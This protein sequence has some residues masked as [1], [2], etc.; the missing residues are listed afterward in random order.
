M[1]PLATTLFS[2]TAL[3]VAALLAV[4]PAARAQTGSDAGLA[5]LR[6]E[7]LRA[8]VGFLASDALQGRAAGT[9][10]NDIAAEY[11]AAQFARLGLTRIAENGTSWFQKFDG[12]GRGAGGPTQNVLGYLEGT[13]PKLED[14]YVVVGAHFDHVGLGRVGSRGGVSPDDR[15]HNGADDNASGTAGM[16]ELA[17]AFAAAPPRRSI[18]FMGFSAEEVGLLGSYYYCANPILPLDKAVAMFNFDMIGRSVDDYLFLGGCGTSPQWP[19]LVTKHVDK[20]GLKVERGEGGR[21]PSDNT[22]FYQAGMPVLFFFTNVHEDYH[23]ATDHAEYINHEGQLTIVRAGYN[24]IRE[25]VDAT[26]RIQFSKNDGFDMPA[27]FQERMRTP[28]RRRD[29]TDKIRDA[30]KDKADDKAGLA[31]LGVSLDESATGRQL[32]VG[33]V[34]EGGLAAKAGVEAGDALVRIDSTTIR[35]AADIERALAGK[36]V[37]DRVDVVVKRGRGRKTLRTRL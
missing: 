17:E 35:K 37:G 11:L 23:R 3:A 36:E 10:H 14:E 27:D 4:V 5:S 30:A 32:V 6:I 15:I 24:L 29:L 22:P 8:H 26:R 18:L 33:A 12:S 21:A 1:R 25:V 13:D 9:E 16:L 34:T 2:S 31:R 7:D 28:E 19:A 20:A